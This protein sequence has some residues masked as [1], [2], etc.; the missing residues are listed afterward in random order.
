MPTK[1]K[2]SSTYETEA[3]DA[4]AYEFPFSDK[5][6]AEAKIR[7]RLRRKKLGPFDPQRINLLRRLKDD[8]QKEIS[9]FEK[10][11]YFTYRHDKYCDMQDF[12]IPRL[13]RKMIER[14]PLIPKKE[15][16]NFVP[17]CVLLYY[18]K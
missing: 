13:T 3:L 17:F 4:L 1:K 7:T 9:K 6:E 18:L 8:L 10:S 12:D 16:E 5:A 2:R 15:I 14:Y 11:I